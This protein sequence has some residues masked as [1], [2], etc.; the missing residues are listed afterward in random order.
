F[1]VGKRTREK[2]LNGGKGCFM[3]GS[4]VKFETSTHSA[5]EFVY[6][7]CNG[8]PCGDITLGVGSFAP[9]VI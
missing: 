9:K 3:K 1:E 2:E 4:G 6:E 7:Y 5:P 8:G